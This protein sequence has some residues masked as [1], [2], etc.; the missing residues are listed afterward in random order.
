MVNTKKDLSKVNSI[1]GILWD[2]W[3]WDFSPITYSFPTTADDYPGAVNGFQTLNNTQKEATRLAFRE[4]ANFTNLSFFESTG[5]GTIKLS[6]ATAVDTDND[7]DDTADTNVTTALGYAPSQ[8]HVDNEIAGNVFFNPTGY[9]NPQ[10]GSFQ[11][12]AGILHEIGHALGLKHPHQTQGAA[13]T[14]EGSLDGIAYTLMSYRDYPG[15]AIDDILDNGNLPQS[16]MM[17]DIAAL[18]Y[19]YG[20]NYTLNNTSTVYRWTPNLVGTT[21]FFV[22]G[23]AFEPGLAL[24]SNTVF[25]TI[26]DGGGTDTYDFSEYTTNLTVNLNPGKWTSLGTQLAQLEDSQSAPGNIANALLFNGDTRSLIENAIGGSGNDLIAGNQGFNRLEGRAGTDTLQGLDGY[27]TLEGGAGDDALD[28]GEG[29]DWASYAGSSAGVYVDLSLGKLLYGDAQG[30][31]LVSIENLIGSNFDDN[32]VGGDIANTFHGGG[33]SDSLSGGGGDDLL[34]GQEGH[35]TLSG[36]IGA[37]YMDGGAGADWSSYRDSTAGV[38][39]DLSAWKIAGIGGTAQGD[40]MVDVENILGSDHN[41]VIGGGDQAN[42]FSGYGGNDALTGLGGNDTLDGSV[43]EDTIDGGIGDDLIQVVASAGDQVNGGGGT[44]W[45]IITRDTGQPDWS[46][47]YG[48]GLGSDG[49]KASAFTRIDV[50]GGTA[51]ETITG[52]TAADLI[53]GGGGSDTLLGNEGNDTISGGAGP[54]SIDGGAGT[55]RADY[56]GSGAVTVDLATGTHTGGDAEGDTLK[57]IEDLSGSASGDSLTGNAAANTLLGQAGADSLSGDAGNDTLDG[58]LGQD[59]L[60]GA[61]GQDAF[62]FR[63]TPSEADADQITDFDPGD[64][65]IQLDSAVFTG[66]SAGAIPTSDFVIGTAALDAS[67][68]LI[69]DDTIGALMFDVDGT[70]VVASVRFVSV[71]PALALT[72]TN[73]L[74]V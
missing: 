41:D 25:R 43:G 31:T 61:A 74:I 7:K 28:G 29:L 68:R 67:D 37:D 30:D 4:I 47:D 18:Q 64:D 51:N 1:D 44:D 63:V 49:F 42:W 24:A 8:T 35:D 20:A 22:N 3:K 5:P 39:I 13:G 65:T 48:S 58:G 56:A 36:G 19:L 21:N 69:Y 11:F 73:F 54:D 72:N 70:G 45:L 32:L 55:D 57:G 46:F 60:T 10:A 53:N 71:T 17:L 14:L 27:D 16:Y 66:L 50:Y 12:A 59:G 2:G 15:D 33:G 6:N 52:A 23:T 62:V 34:G 9:T 40:T 26:W 38:T